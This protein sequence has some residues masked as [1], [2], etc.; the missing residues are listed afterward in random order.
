MHGVLTI[1]GRSVPA[2]VAVEAD[3]REDEWRVRGKTRVKQTGVG[4]KPFSGFGGTVSVKDE[5][6]IEIALTLR[7]RERTRAPDPVSR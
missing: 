3:R 7:P 4:I 5:M 6:E 2:D 1:R